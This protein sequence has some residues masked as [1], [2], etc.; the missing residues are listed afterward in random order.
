MEGCVHAR[1]WLRE[2][3]MREEMGFLVGLHNKGGGERTVMGVV[4][5]KE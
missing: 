2:R 5:Y 4:A 3:E 1:V